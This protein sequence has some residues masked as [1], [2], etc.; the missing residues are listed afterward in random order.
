[1]PARLLPIRKPVHD[2]KGGWKAKA[3]IVVCGNFEPSSIAKGLENRAEVPS[4][5]EMRTLL[6]LGGLGGRVR[7][8]FPG[9]PGDQVLPWS[10]GSLD[11]KTAFLYAELIEEEDGIVVVQPLAVLVRLGLVPPGVMWKLKKALYGLRCAPKRWSQKRDSI[12]ADLTCTVDGEKASFEQ[13]KTTRGSG[14][15]EPLKRPWGSSSCM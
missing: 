6:A 1:M 2:G 12:L 11:V 10:V 4:T 15:S 7:A 14:N 9:Q 8:G 13:C 5:F 3:R